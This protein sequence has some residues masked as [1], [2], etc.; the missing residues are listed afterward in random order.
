MSRKRKLSIED[1]AFSCY[2]CGCDYETS[3]DIVPRI[4]PC[5]HSMCERCI[6]QAIQ[7]DEL[8]CAKC[9]K[10]HEAVNGVK[11]FPENNYIISIL[12]MLKQDEEEEFDLC[13][14]HKRELSLY[15]KQNGCGGTLCQVCFIEKHNGHDIVDIIKE[16]QE[17]IEDM[18]K[19]LSRKRFE[20]M[21]RKKSKETL[22][23][24]KK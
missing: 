6:E 13:D 22:K 24:W 2:T 19:L 14:D 20:E 16:H 23:R 7:E 9:G 12:K 5:T 21:I 4:F 8:Y 11:S 18:I 17:N 15:C 3:G 10:N 1:D